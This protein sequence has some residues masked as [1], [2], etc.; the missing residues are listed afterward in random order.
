MV[1]RL[2]ARIAKLEAGKGVE[3]SERA[4]AWLGMRPPLTAEEDAVLPRV[5]PATVDRSNWSPQMREWLGR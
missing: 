5:D 4:K 2:S 1:G 3:L